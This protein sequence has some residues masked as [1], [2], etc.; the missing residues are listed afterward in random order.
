MRSRERLT[1]TVP[2]AVLAAAKA[3]VA[4]GAAP[5]VSAWITEAAT[6]KA[7][8]EGLAEVLAD[9]LAQSGGPLTDEERSW[10]ESHL[11]LSSSTPAH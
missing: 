2:H 7:R 1:V 10:A 4:A 11:G 8:R 9:L 6:T 5:S 3:D